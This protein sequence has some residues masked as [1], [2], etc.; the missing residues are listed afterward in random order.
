MISLTQ[1]QMRRAAAVEFALGGPDFHGD[2]PEGVRDRLHTTVEIALGWRDR[3]KILLGWQVELTV[4]T[5]T[6]NTV[7]ATRSFTDIRFLRPNWAIR[8]RSLMGGYSVLPEDKEAAQVSGN[9]KGN[10]WL[11]SSGRK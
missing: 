6:E 3:L 8:R 7:G 9:Y 10:G 1:K 4:R 11:D 5:N 2:L